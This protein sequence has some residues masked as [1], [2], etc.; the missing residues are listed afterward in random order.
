MRPGIF[1]SLPLCLA[2]TLIL[3]ARAP[4]AGKVLLPPRS[5]AA[6]VTQ[7]VGLTTITVDYNSPGV[8]NRKIWT[9]VVPPGV[10]WRTGEGTVPVIRFSRDV[11]VADQAVRAGAYSLLT[12]PSEASWTIILNRD[13]KLSSL[14]A[15]R[16]DMDVAR[17]QAPASA[18][19]FRER[20]T[21]LFTDFSTEQASL[22]LEWEKVRVAIPIHVRTNEQVMA[23][24]HSLDELWRR[25]AD[26]AAYMLQ[27]KKDYDAGLK[28]V[29]RSIALKESWYNLWVKASLL[30]AKGD[31]AGARDSADRAY[32]LGRRSSD[33]LPFEAAMKQ[34]LE[35]WSRSAGE[36]RPPSLAKGWADRAPGAP[37][38]AP[39]TGLPPE[40]A[41][42][43][44]DFTPR[45]FSISEPTHT[46][47]AIVRERSVRVRRA[48]GGAGT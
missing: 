29:N 17:V 4:G 32:E 11:V 37:S 5:P 8:A 21:F 31:Y 42:T 22:D 7:E 26:T 9:S 1:V 6:S 3:E 38:A 36:Q 19:P 28:Y 15:Y 14:A 45:A 27:T 2:A 10:L 16:P 34:G 43:D 46:P 13:T 23:A 18:V 44:S 35:S 24:I 33:G 48:E 41:L 47:V 39:P 25:Y 30:A 40:L 20:L 12:I